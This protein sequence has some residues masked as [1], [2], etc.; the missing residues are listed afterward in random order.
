M[1][2]KKATSLS[3]SFSDTGPTIEQIQTLNQLVTSKVMV[4]EV[5]TGEE[6]SDDVPA[7]IGHLVMT[8]LDLVIGPLGRTL[9]G[10]PAHGGEPIYELDSL[11]R[12]DP[13][14]LSSEPIA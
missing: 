11:N 9:I 8:H 3:I 5:L 2:A 13:L 1:V 12:I 4:A 14:R 6:V 7:S 10:N